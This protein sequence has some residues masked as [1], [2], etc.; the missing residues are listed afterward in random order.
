MPTA[1]MISRD[2]LKHRNGL[3]DPVLNIRILG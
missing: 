1:R 2:E 3:G